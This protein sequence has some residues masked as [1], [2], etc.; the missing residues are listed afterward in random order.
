MVVPEVVVTRGFGS[1]QEEGNKTH[2]GQVSIMKHDQG[3]NSSISGTGR[4]A[5]GKSLPKDSQVSMMRLK[6]WQNRVQVKNSQ[7]KN[8]R[9]S[10]TRIGKFGSKI[11][12]ERSCWR[13]KPRKYIERH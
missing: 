1:F 8:L 6:Q 9:L 10:F 4:D 11:K 3:I 13:T 7:D 5:S 12:L 2:S